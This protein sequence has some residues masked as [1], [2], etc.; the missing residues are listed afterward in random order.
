[1]LNAARHKPL[2]LVNRKF[3][4]LGR[5]RVQL[6]IAMAVGGAEVRPLLP[7]RLLNK[8]HSK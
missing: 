6:A 1:M 2:R 8:P 5:P 7:R 3:H 4:V